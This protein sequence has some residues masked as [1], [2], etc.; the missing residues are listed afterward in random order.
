MLIVA[1]A[2]LAVAG[3]AAGWALSYH[4]WFAAYDLAGRAF[5]GRGTPVLVG[6]VT[7]LMVWELSARLRP[8]YFAAALC[9]ALLMGVAGHLLEAGL[10]LVFE[11]DDEIWPVPMLMA[12]GQLWTLL[13]APL[14]ALC[15]WGRRRHSA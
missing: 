10:P 6:L 1:R 11:A 3:L 5:I 4:A 12:S 7:A 2:V 9:G 13:G 15:W 8:G 14:G